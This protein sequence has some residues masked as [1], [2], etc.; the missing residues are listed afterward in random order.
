VEKW[1]LRHWGRVPP[2][3]ARLEIEGG[4]T[5]TAAE[6]GPRRIRRLRITRQTLPVPDELEPEKEATVL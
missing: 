4:F 1:A 5:L 3:G 6:V 2:T